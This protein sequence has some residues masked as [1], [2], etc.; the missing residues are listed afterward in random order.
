MGRLFTSV[1][2]SYTLALFLRSFTFGHVRQLDAF[3]SRLLINLCTCAPLL[4]GADKLANVDIDDTVEPTF[5]YATQGAGRGDSAVKRLN[6][7]L[8]IIRTP[9]SR[10][11][12]AAARLRRGANNSAQGTF[13]L[14]V[15]PLVIAKVCG[16]EMAEI[17]FT[18][19]SIKTYAKQVAARLI[20]RHFSDFK[21]AHQSELFTV[22]RDHVLSTHSLL[23]MLETDKAH[24]S[25]TIVEQV[26]ADLNSGLL[27]Q[28]AHLPS[29]SFTANCASP[30]LAAI[31]FHHTR[32]S[33][34]LASAFHAKATTGAIRAQLINIPAKVPPPLFPSCFICLS[35][36]RREPPGRD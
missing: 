10:P 23:P 21:S 33:G 25:L 36:G 6:A 5:G 22:Y 34:C 35:T 11:V 13:R 28:L 8:G 7:P 32:A 14:A 12:I 16:A 9:S 31:G 27:A 17:E 30:V 26:N 18:A 1:H 19:S 29:Q 20:V 3:A 15:D 4:P 2:A 24:P